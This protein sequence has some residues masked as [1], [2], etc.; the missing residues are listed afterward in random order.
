M[1]NSLADNPPALAS[2]RPRAGMID[3]SVAH[4]RSL[5]YAHGVLIIHI[6]VCFHRVDVT[7]LL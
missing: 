3:G 4:H 1:E 6:R 2:S 7:S 5:A